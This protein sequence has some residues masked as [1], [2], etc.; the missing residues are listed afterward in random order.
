MPGGWAEQ[1]PG[2]GP[3]L[4]TVEMTLNKKGQSAS[5]SPLMRIGPTAA[6]AGVSRQTLQYYVLVGLVKPA[7]KSSSGQR[8]FDKKAIP[9]IKLIRKLNRSG[10]T[11]R[12]I[13][14]IFLAKPSAGS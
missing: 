10:Y 3:A 4:E 14:E 5:S 9:R 8:L 7:C 1:V 6:G 12:D 2:S 13:R 11:L